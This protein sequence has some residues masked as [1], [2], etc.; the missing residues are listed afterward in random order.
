MS[1]VK[2]LRF[3]VSFGDV[4]RVRCRC[5]A[6]GRDGRGAL[7]GRPCGGHPRARE[8]RGSG[9]EDPRTRTRSLVGKELTMNV[10]DVMTRE[11]TTVRPTR[12]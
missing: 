6:R 5:G 8:R 9:S 2:A 10:E 7:P 12:A 11:V 3:P 4:A 1:I